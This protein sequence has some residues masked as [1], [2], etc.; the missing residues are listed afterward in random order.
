MCGDQ[1]V[2]QIQE[3]RNTTDFKVYV[4]YNKQNMVKVFKCPI[5]WME[6]R[7]QLHITII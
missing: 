5:S 2:K 7:N 4:Y 6:E 1:I 3:K